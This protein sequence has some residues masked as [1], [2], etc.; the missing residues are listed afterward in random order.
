MCHVQEGIN[1]RYKQLK[2]NPN[3]HICADENTNHVE[4]R[5]HKINNAETTVVYEELMKTENLNEMACDIG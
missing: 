4:K 1:I 5:A 3:Y 2:G